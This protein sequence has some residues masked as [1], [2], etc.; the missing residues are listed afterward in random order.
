[1]NRVL[2]QVFGGFVVK[3]A[4]AK[5]RKKRKFHKNAILF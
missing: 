4:A 3:D 2:N 5:S 1:M